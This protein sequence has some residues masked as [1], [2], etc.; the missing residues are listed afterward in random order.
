MLP[1]AR[2]KHRGQ[3]RPTSRASSSKTGEPG[4]QNRTESWTTWFQFISRCSRDCISEWTTIHYIYYVLDS[5][6]LSEPIVT[7]CWE[8]CNAHI[9]GI[10]ITCEICPPTLACLHWWLGF[11]TNARRFDTLLCS[12]STSLMTLISFL[13]ESLLPLPIH[14]SP[15]L[16][17]KLQVFGNVPTLWQTVLA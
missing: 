10:Q 15:D 5:L 3:C 11:P 16:Q 6:I 14:E 2:R 8:L 17:E 9:Q 1:E 12:C 7:T 4:Q 13:I